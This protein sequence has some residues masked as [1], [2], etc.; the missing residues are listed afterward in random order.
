MKKGRRRRKRKTCPASTPPSAR[1][2]LSF[3]GPAA[4]AADRAWELGVTAPVDGRVLRVFHA[5]AA[6]V[7]PATPEGTPGV[8][9]IPSVIRPEPPLASSASTWPW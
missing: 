9:G 2:A 6:I 7:S 8:D 4:R 1:A 5:D 3:S